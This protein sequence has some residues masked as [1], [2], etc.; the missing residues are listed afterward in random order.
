MRKRGGRNETKRA[1]GDETRRPIGLARGLRRVGLDFPVDRLTTNVLGSIEVNVASI[2]LFRADPTRCGVVLLSACGSGRV[3]RCQ[4]VDVDVNRC[5][6]GWDGM[7]IDSRGDVG[8]ERVRIVANAHGIKF[9]GSSPATDD[10]AAAWLEQ[11][12]RGGKSDQAPVWAVS[13][14]RFVLEDYN[15]DPICNLIKLFTTLGDL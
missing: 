3:R 2:R 11:E 8:S 9:G 14:A 12:K 5:G 13:S 6:T 1:R 10:A 4:V 15:L 7:S